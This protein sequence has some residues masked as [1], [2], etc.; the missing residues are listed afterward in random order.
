M[1]VKADSKASVEIFIV[2]TELD[3]K[4]RCLSI[5]SAFTVL[6]NVSDLERLDIFGIK[7][8]LGLKFQGMWGPELRASEEVRLFVNE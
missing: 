8:T 2:G 6:V 4:S 1:L 7:L 3:K 5:K